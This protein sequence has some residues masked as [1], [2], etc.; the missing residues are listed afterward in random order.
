VTRRVAEPDIPLD[1]V[2]RV[3][4]G[5][6][7][8]MSGGRPMS[9]NCLVRAGVD[10]EIGVLA[11]VVGALEELGLVRRNFVGRIPQGFAITEE[12]KIA[13]RDGI[14]WAR[15]P[16]T[17]APEPEW[18]IRRRESADRA[19]RESDLV[20]ATRLVVTRLL[21]RA[22]GALVASRRTLDQ[23]GEGVV[24][25]LSTLARWQR[26]AIARAAALGDVT[27]S[28]TGVPGQIEVR[29]RESFAITWPPREP[30]TS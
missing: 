26:P 8:Q 20:E 12:G 7:A 15:A 21:E 5:A 13:A 2:E 4:R 1:V 30:G 25:H 27:A 24:D 11:R 3:A 19:A 28:S 9:I 6:L 29:F 17:I 16:L 10:A 23:L 18:S 14:A 22:G